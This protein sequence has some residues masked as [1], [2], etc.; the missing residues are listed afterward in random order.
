MP[1]EPD[2]PAT[3][4]LFIDERKNQ[5]AYWV[6]QLKRCSADYEILE[7]SDGQSGLALYRSRQIDCVG[8]ELSLP[9]QSGFEVLMTLVP[10]ARRPH[11]AVVVLT[12]MTHRG[13]WELARQNGAYT[14]LAKNFTSGE[15][16]DRA[17]QRAVAF[18]EQMPKEDRYRPL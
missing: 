10:I 11:I 16:L 12:H 13:V 17:I 14:C 1:Q 6:D 4:V 15:D 9:S 3:S 2:I 8:L 7:A 5:R 18:V